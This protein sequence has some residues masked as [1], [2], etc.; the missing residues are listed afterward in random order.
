M[1][2]E[3]GRAVLTAFAEGEPAAAALVREWVK[4]LAALV[5]SVH[6]AYDP[7]SVANV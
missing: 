1:D 5:Y 3:D 6:N 2:G 4:A 7:P